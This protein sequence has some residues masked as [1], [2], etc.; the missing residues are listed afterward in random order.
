MGRVLA[1]AVALA[2][3]L[4]VALAA[5]AARAGGSRVEWAA[6]QIREG[7]DA[8]RIEKK[9][10]ALL[11]KAAKRAQWGKG[12]KL[13]LVV[14]VARLDWEDHDDVARVDVKAVARIEGAAPVRTRI[15]MGGHTR[16]R[17]RL[18]EQALRVV[19]EGVVTR[20]SAMA[21]ERAR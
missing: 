1:L 7:D 17:R 9:L 8:P 3:A 10:R 5:P 13:R 2:L 6:V 4:A 12:D 21:R 20:L 14:H 18:E 16:E 11:Q 15:R 19:A